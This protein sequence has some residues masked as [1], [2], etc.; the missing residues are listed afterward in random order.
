MTSPSPPGSL[1]SAPRERWAV[2][3]RITLTADPEILAIAWGQLGDRPELDKLIGRQWTLPLRLSPEQ[4]AQLAGLA[5]DKPDKLYQSIREAADG[6]SGA[7]RFAGKVGATFV[8]RPWFWLALALLAAAVIFW[9]KLRPGPLRAIL[10]AITAAAGVF[11]AG[12]AAVWGALR[13]LRDKTQAA[14]RQVEQYADT[15]R[16]RLQ[17]ALDAT[18]VQ[19]EALQA[20]Q[21]AWHSP[22][23]LPKSRG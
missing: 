9:L 12:A 15:R 6:I 1:S 14:I 2:R 11:G 22:H 19:V 4:Q 13:Q 8:R 5:G 10:S 21:S 7:A 18:R 17:T 23:V 16:R 3:P 20:V